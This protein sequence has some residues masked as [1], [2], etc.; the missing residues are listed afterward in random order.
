MVIAAPLLRPDLFRRLKQTLR[1]RRGEG[2]DLEWL[3]QASQSEPFAGDVRLSRKQRT[4]LYR[5]LAARLD[6]S[7]L[8]ALYFGL[9]LPY[10]S[11]TDGGTIDHAREL[12]AY[13]ARARR[14]DE[15]LASLAQERPDLDLGEWSD[16]K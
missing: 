9:D 5:L 1:A 8:R 12:V 2:D 7:D 13:C 10:D 16:V 3:A 14:L 6:E 11:L 4:A 15:L